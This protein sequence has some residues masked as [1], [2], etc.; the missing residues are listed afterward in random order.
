MYAPTALLGLS[1]H[2]GDFVVHRN[3]RC[4]GLLAASLFWKPSWLCLVPRRVIFKEEAF[5]SVLAKG[6][7]GPVIEVRGSFSYRDLPSTSQLVVL[8]NSMYCFGK[9]DMRSL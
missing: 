5:R 9:F 7:L 8:I 2:D 3:H 4:A 1:C 6:T